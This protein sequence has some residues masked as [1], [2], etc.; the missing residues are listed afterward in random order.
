MRQN[1]HSSW[2]GLPPPTANPDDPNASCTATSTF[3]PLNV[4]GYPIIDTSWRFYASG[5]FNGD[6]ITDIVWLKP[7]GTLLVW[8]MNANGASP[9]V[10]DNA[11]IAPA[12]YTVFQP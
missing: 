1:S 8:Q 2:F 10:I 11:G 9:T 5:D 3:I 12:G 7:N 6:G 4:Y